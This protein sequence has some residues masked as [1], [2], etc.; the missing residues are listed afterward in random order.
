[1]KL[2]IALLLCMITTLSVN[3]QHS[4]YLGTKGERIDYDTAVVINID[5]YRKE[6]Q[7]QHYKDF[8]ID[9]LQQVN[10][11]NAEKNQQTVMASQQMEEAVDKSISGLNENQAAKKNKKWYRNPVFG[12]GVGMLIGIYLIPANNF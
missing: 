12:L 9:S 4:R 11:M 1:M 10:S 5:V 2:L 7:I 6:L 8:L 3:A